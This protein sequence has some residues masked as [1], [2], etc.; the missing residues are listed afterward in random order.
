MNRKPLFILLAV[1][2]VAALLFFGGRALLGDGAS[3]PLKL[4]GNIDVREVDLAFRVGGR[5]GSIA[6]DEGDTVTAGQELATLDTASLDSRVRQAEA[7]VAASRAQLARARSGSRSQEIAQADARVVAAQ[8]A[9]TSANRDY[10]RR[11][12]LVGPGAISRDQWDNTVAEKQRAEAALNEARATASLLRAG[13]RAEDIAAADANVRAA[14]AARDSARIDTGD[15]RL[16]APLA[17]TIMTRAREPGAIVQPTETVLTLAITRPL[18]V[19]AYIAEPDLSRISPGMKVNVTADGNA[20]TYQG[21]IGSIASKAE[22]TPKSVETENLRTDLVYQV[23]IIVDNPDDAL[24]QGQPVTVAI[25]AARP[26]VK[27]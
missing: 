1:A 10:Q 18:R 23:R 22:F 17:G 13:S 7:Q 20:K 11:Q 16:V 14:E 3:G 4:Y 5:I 2:A 26:V 15:S 8:A 24:R 25:P 21:R 19:R 27:K 9:F 6:V 12:P